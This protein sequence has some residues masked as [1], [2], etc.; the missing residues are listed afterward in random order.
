MVIIGGIMN[1][2]IALRKANKLALKCWKEQ[3]KALYP[4]CVMCGSTKRLN[5]HHLLSYRLYKKYRYDINNGLSLCSGCHK[6]RK[7]SP[8]QDPLIFA[9]W[10]NKNYPLIYNYAVR[11]GKL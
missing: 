11:V 3:V 8:H 2:K 10:L 9:D 1:K 5:A 7:G 6:F 4:K